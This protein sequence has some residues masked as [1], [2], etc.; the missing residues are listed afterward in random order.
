MSAMMTDIG[1][2]GLSC[3]GTESFETPYIDQLATEGMRF[4]SGYSLYLRPNT[5]VFPDWHLRV[6]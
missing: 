2:W 5:L 4:T 1:L 3:Y 6:S